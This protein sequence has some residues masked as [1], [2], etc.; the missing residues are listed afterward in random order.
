MFPF[1]L[2][3]LEVQEISVAETE[4]TV[5]ASTT[6]KTAVCPRCQQTSS[7]LH[8]FYTRTPRDLPM[9]GQAVRLNLRVRRFRCQTQACPKQTFVEPLPQVVERSARQTDRLRTILKLFATALS[10]QAGERLLKPLGMAV[11][12][13]TL[14][15]L[16]KS[17]K[18]AV[19]QAPEILGVDDFAF[20][21]GRTYGTILLDLQT[22]RPIDLLPERTADALSLWLRTHPGVLVVSR[23]RSTEFA[24]GASDGAP[25]AVQIADRFHLLQ[26]LREAC[27][28]ALKRMHANLIEQ[29]KAAGLSPATRYKRRRSQ[30]EIAASKVARLRRQ[31]R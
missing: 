14:L 23:D 26:N 21:R 13:Q 5:M 9:S 11:S 30:T 1:L 3:G 22:H 2:P 28:R 8:S 19:V 17:T 7:R 15:R 16:A 18:T 6:G 25:E 12:G 29:H 20:K 24:R 4:I 10:G 27:E 31:A